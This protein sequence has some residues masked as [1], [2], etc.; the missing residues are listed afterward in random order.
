[1]S[2]PVTEQRSHTH[3]PRRIALACDTS[4]HTRHAFV[5]CLSQLCHPKDVLVLIHVSTRAEEESHDPYSP[6]EPSAEQGAELTESEPDVDSLDGA[7]SRHDTESEHCSLSGGWQV[8][9]KYIQICKQAQLQSMAVLTRGDA[10]ASS[11]VE[12]A[13]AHDCDLAVV[14]SRCLGAFKRALSPSFSTHTLNAISFPIVVV[15]WGIQSLDA[16]LLNLI[17][18]GLGEEEGTSTMGRRASV[19]EAQSPERRLSAS[20]VSLSSISVAQVGRALSDNEGVMARAVSETR[21]MALG[22]H[23]TAEVD[24]SEP[25]QRVKSGGSEGVA[26]G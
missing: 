4:E 22:A 19:P 25:L 3:L 20:G 11:F 1:M 2:E 7:R 10:P 18:A 9:M 14:G 23:T 26:T 8:L 15:R 21:A 17:P 16:N 13:A 5:W 24:D 6:A 12:A